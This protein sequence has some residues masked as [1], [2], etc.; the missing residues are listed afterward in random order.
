MLNIRNSVNSR[1]GWS[2]AKLSLPVLASIIVLLAAQLACQ[3]LSPDPTAAPPQQLV[4]TSSDVQSGTYSLTVINESDSSIC[5]LYVSP[6]ASDNW[7]SDQLG[8]D[9]VLDA[10]ESFEV[11]NIDPGVYDLRA[12]TCDDEEVTRHDVDFTEDKTWT[13]TNN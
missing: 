7:G 3:A 6:D 9:E 8:E 5:Y 1:L 10:G 13:I 12:V 2:R 4:P 11:F